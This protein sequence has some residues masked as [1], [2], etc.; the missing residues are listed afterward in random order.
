MPLK[1]KII[2]VICLVVILTLGVSTALLVKVQQE[3]LMEGKLDDARMISS[4][5]E[6]SIT[7]AMKSGKSD[8][9]QSII[10]N[11]GQGEDITTLRILAK[12]GRIL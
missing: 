10:E 5:I 2:T 12:D 4:L 1:T 9:V 6:R 11:I 3:K 8:E 7:S